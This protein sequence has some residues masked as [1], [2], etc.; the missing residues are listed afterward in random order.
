M[1]RLCEITLPGLRGVLVARR[2]KKHRTLILLNIPLA[3]TGVVLA[4]LV[5]GM[6]FSISAAVGFIAI[7]GIAG[8][9]GI[10]LLTY[11]REL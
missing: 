5:L 3:A 7:F 2:A 1:Q 8:L 10:V 4:L 6:P 9:N 11:I